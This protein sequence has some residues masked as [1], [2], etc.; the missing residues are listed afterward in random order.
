[1]KVKSHPEWLRIM[2]IV[3]PGHEQFLHFL[4]PCTALVAFLAAAPW[5]ER[6]ASLI[7]PVGLLAALPHGL[8]WCSPVTGIEVA[9]VRGFG[10]A[11]ARSPQL[12]ESATVADGAS[13]K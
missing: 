10:G 6:T 13:S 1:M 2:V 12:N 9:P 4:S 7:L 5:L 3:G 8:P 11:A